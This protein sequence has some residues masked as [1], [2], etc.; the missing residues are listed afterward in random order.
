MASRT[1]AQRVDVFWLKDPGF[2]FTVKGDLARCR[3]CL[4]EGFSYPIQPE[5]WGFRDKSQ[6]KL[7]KPA[8][9]SYHFVIRMTHSTYVLVGNLT[10][11][12]EGTV[13]VN[14]E[15]QLGEGCA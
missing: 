14:G 8:D 10:E 9:Q 7:I 12:S 3:Q 1:L 13:K 4:Q 2:A 15:V 5:G 11:T 6:T